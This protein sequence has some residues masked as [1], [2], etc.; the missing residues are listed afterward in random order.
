MSTVLS[1][2]VL[3]SQIYWTDAGRNS[4][5]V[6]ELDG[7]NRKV[8]VW[9][10]LESPRAIALHYHHGLMYWSDWGSNPR[11]EQAD[12]DGDH[13]LVYA[14]NRLLG[15]PQ[16]RSGCHEEGKHFQHVLEIKAFFPGWR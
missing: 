13:R 15:R 2:Y 6:A 8:L 16:G 3:C 1:D 5:E 12:M 11:I 7:G 10:G 14:W 4:I 9:S